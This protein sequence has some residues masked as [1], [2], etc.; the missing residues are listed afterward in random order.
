[1]DLATGRAKYRLKKSLHPTPTHH[2]G[3]FHILPPFACLPMAIRKADLQ[4]S[5]PHSIAIL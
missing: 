3:N 2:P 4:K 1:M 5:R